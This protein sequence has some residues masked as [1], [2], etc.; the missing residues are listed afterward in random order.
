[1]GGSIGQ[2]EKERF[3]SMD[4]W[5]IWNRNWVVDN[6][7]AS[8]TTHHDHDHDYDRS[9]QEILAVTSS[10]FLSLMRNNVQL[11]PAKMN[12]RRYSTNPPSAAGL[13]NPSLECLAKYA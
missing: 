3:I 2:A 8:L 6:K 11:S 13:I 12:L 4:A 7:D 10:R 9:L 5:M 1:M